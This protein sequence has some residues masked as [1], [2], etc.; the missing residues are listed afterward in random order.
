M[1]ALAPVA[2]A[3]LLLAF[4]LAFGGFA[5]S[6]DPVDRNP[7]GPARLFLVYLVL[8][9]S[10]SGLITLL[11]GKLM[12]FTPDPV[13]Y[14][15]VYLKTAL[16]TLLAVLGFNLAYWQTSRRPVRLP[17]RVAAPWDARRQALLGLGLGF[18][19]YVAAFLLVQSVGGLGAALASREELRSGG[20]IGKGYL[21]YPL[22]VGTA[23]SALLLVDLLFRRPASAGRN[24]WIGLTLL[25][26]TIPP[27]LTGFRGGILLSI[28]TVGIY[29][30]QNVRSLYDRRGLLAFGALL[31]FFTGYGV[32][33]AVPPRLDLLPAV[34]RVA[35]EDPA[36][37][38]GPLT[39]SAGLESAAG[40]VRG[41]DEDPRIE[42]EWFLSGVVETL[43][44]PV[45]LTLWPDKPTS[46][47]I[48]SGEIFFLNDLRRDRGA[49]WENAGGIS[50][51]LVGWG[52][53]Q[54]YALGVFLAGGLFG[55][56]IRRL[57]STE[58]P[59]RDL[60]A[61]R[62]GYAF[63]AP[64][65]IL[66][67]ESPQGYLNGFFLNLIAMTGVVAWMGVP[68]ARGRRLSAA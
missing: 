41:M 59:H 10:V 52:Y 35:E 31:A 49:D 17:K 1:S 3:A 21:L 55:G 29:V 4:P 40:V 18:S 64:S 14:E 6:R 60:S 54:G 61:V 39:R 36:L 37:F 66:A 53:W 48:R 45:P 7:L 15:G 26:A 58:A 57:V 50:I 34:A 13:E 65:L 28:F 56:L 2:A 67:S 16:L 68:A 25:A 42:P 62:I 46:S 63:L 33:R 8:Q 5:R 12:P 23:L 9:L 32:W 38:F 47:S 20:L 44:I 43:T 22:T 19:G 11:V 24:A 30:H 27:F 51:T